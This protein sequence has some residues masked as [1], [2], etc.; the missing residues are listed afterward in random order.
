MPGLKERTMR[1]LARAVVGIAFLIALVLGC[2]H[3]PSGAGPTRGE[4]QLDG[5]KFTVRTQ[6]PTTTQSTTGGPSAST[7]PVYDFRFQQLMTY[8]NPG[9][10]GGAPM[11]SAASN[12]GAGRPP[13]APPVRARRVDFPV[14]LEIN[15]TESYRPIQEN[16]FLAV[17]QDPLSTF[18]ADVDTAS[19]SIVRRFLTEGHLPPPDAVRIE[20]MVNYFPYAYSPPQG[21]APF[22]VRAEVAECP[23]DLTHRLVLFGLKGR[24]IPL[25]KRPPSNLVFL[26]DVSGSMQPEN[27]LPLLKRSLRL[28]VEQLT[29]TDRVAIITYAGAAG[30]ALPPTPGNQKVNILAAIDRLESG[31]STNGGAGVELAYKTAQEGLIV[32]GTNRVILCTDGDWNVGTT[33]DGALTRLIAEKAKGGVQL[34]VLGFGMGNL[35]DG[36]MEQLADKG[37]GNYAYID[38]LNEGRKVLVEQMA[39]TLLTIAKDVKLQV[40]F[41]PQ[42]VAAYRLIGYEDRLMAAEDFRNDRKDAGEIGSGHTVTALYEVIPADGKVDARAD[43]VPLKYQARA[44]PTDAAKNGEMLTLLVRCKEPSAEASREIAFPLADPVKRLSDASGDFKFAAAVA[45]FGM[46][47]RGSENKGSANFDTVLELATE[48]KGADPGGHREEFLSLVKKAKAIPR[49]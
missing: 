7:P 9:R 15:A 31:G 13:A 39:G 49:K 17:A 23:W 46:I 25:D 42:V 11:I 48:G 37:N 19:Y 3:R 41:N 8:S 33:D 32:G 26:I 30:L 35:K 38:T 43:V 22:S 2:H 10:A 40:E 4:T 27:K 5:L 12:I 44:T 29:M 16:P 18:S 47:L 21:D 20:E 45:T 24:E 36:M 1:R 28:L 34:T 6:V 14:G